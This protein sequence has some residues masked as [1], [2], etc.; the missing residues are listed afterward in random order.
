MFVPLPSDDLGE[1][2]RPTHPR[3]SFGL[4]H[5]K[6][7]FGFGV[8]FGHKN[9]F[10]RPALCPLLANIAYVGNIDSPDSP[11]H[12]NREIKRSHALSR[13]NFRVKAILLSG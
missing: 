11:I 10:V 13:S 5:S 8:R 9:C 6:D 7:L 4:L 3:F 2:Q 1:D 12:E